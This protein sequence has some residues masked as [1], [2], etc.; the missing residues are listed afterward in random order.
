MNDKTPDN[1]PAPDYTA[2]RG[3]T[4][5]VLAHPDQ[6]SAEEVAV[7]RL[8]QHLLP[9]PTLTDM[10]VTER[11]ATVGMWATIDPGDDSRAWRGIIARANDHVALV[12]HPDDMRA[13]L[14]P[15]AVTASIV[16]PDP[17]VPRAWNADGT[18][19]RPESESDGDE[20]PAPAPTAALP[21]GWWLADHPEHGRVVVVRPE[22]DDEGEV[23]IIVSEPT[24]IDH[25]A[26]T[27]CDPD[28]LTY[29][30]ADEKTTDAT[31]TEVG[32]IIE[33]A[34]DPRFKTLPVGSVLLDRDG[35][36]MTKR[37]GDIG[38]DSGTRPSRP[39]ATSS[40]RGRYAVSDR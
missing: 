37:E 36:T 30:G 3:Y 29:V 2:A 18:P 9:T 26:V 15:T 33:S 38:Q 17:S 4:A 23:A 20:K 32:D 12:C 25:A 7:A 8:L 21:D 22:P 16:T 40:A 11:A 39:K 31:P 35:V 24:N 10:T 6:H 1:A 19:A 27:W 14:K 13:G 28:E 34:D 5:R